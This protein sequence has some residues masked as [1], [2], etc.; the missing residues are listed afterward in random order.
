MHARDAK[1]TPAVRPD[2][3]SIEFWNNIAAGRFAV[4]YCATCN[5]YQF[6]P[7]E[8]CRHCAAKLVWRPLSGRGTVHTYIVQHHN[9]LSHEHSTPTVVALISPEEAPELRIP[10]RMRGSPGK[11]AINDRVQIECSTDEP[12]IS[13]HLLRAP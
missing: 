7:L 11:I 5:R 13:F 3:D 4:Q 9:I 8:C 6:P 12:A 10:A 1:R 2:P